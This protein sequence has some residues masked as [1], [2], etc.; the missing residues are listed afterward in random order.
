MATCV[1]KECITKEQRSDVRFLWAEGLNA[2]DIH[3]EMF[4]V[5]GGKCLSSK[6]VHN[7]VA[8]VSLMKKRFKYM[9]GSGWDDS[10]MT[11]ML[12]VSTHW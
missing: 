10:Q 8:N 4:P 1:C 9:Y 11:S 12:R 3:K 6:G 7:R 5:Y 2:K